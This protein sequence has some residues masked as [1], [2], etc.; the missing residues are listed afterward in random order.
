MRDEVEPGLIGFRPANG[1]GGWWLRHQDILKWRMQAIDVD[2][3]DDDDEEDVAIASEQLVLTDSASGKRCPEDGAF[4][5]RY[6]V[7]H[8]LP[9]H[10]DRCGHCCSV[11]LD[12]GEWDALRQAGL[13]RSLHLI[14]TAPWQKAVREQITKEVYESRVASI[15]GPDD[16]HKV[17]EMLDWMKVHPK[18]DT[19]TAYLNEKLNIVG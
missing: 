3:I 17:N 16:Y 11:W 7:G 12:P 19:I 8:D 5:I 14:A 18:L 4:L 6:R 15:L 1:D 2:V 9:F 10:I 13:A